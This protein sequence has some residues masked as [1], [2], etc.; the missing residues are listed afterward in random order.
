MQ[1]E[2]YKLTIARRVTLLSPEAKEFNRR[3]RRGRRERKAA[4]KLSGFVATTGNAVAQTFLSVQHGRG[5]QEC[6]PHQ[7]TG[8]AWFPERG[9]EG[10]EKRRVRATGA[11]T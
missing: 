3:G 6:L 10:A 9:A 5:R 7:T 4:M 1:A 2:R 8:A 11:R